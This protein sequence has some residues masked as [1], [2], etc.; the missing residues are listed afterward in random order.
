MKVNDTYHIYFNN[1]P[2]EKIANTDAQQFDFS[3]SNDEFM[4]TLSSVNIINIYY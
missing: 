3:E 1:V 4:I 2:V